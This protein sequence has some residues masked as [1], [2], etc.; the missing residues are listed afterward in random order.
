M[1]RIEHFD[2]MK[3][4]AIILV[5]IG[6]I[7]LFSFG[8]YG[9]DLEH[10]LVIFHMPV[11]FYVSGFLAYKSMHSGRPILL[12]IWRY[13][14]ALILPL[15]V[16][17]VLWN[18]T[19]H[20]ETLLNMLSRCGGKYW[21]LNTLAVLSIFFTCYEK[22]AGKVKNTVGYCALWFLPFVLLA[23]IKVNVGA[24]CCVSV[25][26]IVTYYRYYLVGFLCCKYDWLNRFLFCNKVVYAWAVATFALDFVLI[27]KNN[28]FL[29]FAGAVSAIIILQNLCEHI[30]TNV[31]PGRY[32]RLTSIGNKTLSIYLI[33]FFFLP[34]LT[35]LVTPI[36]SIGNPFMI[37]LMLTLV[38]S[39]LI[40]PICLL[41]ET[42]IS[43][44]Q[45][46]NF[47]LF[48]KPLK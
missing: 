19:H 43:K 40:I 3:G 35:Q 36:A 2:L 48:G 33:H 6:H 45:Y 32:R 29:T 30:A 4:I 37:H 24:T 27:D 38:I 39:A 20:D 11:F 26:S 17:C 12:Q 18:V 47:L 23:V 41:V 9:S 34:D 15:L 42:I 28:Y 22:L 46:L 5:V 25:D 44:N 21:F 7:M 31:Y 13:T 10:F 8:I 14:R 1:N 16:W